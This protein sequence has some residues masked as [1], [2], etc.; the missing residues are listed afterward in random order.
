MS[1]K[2]KRE[3]IEKARRDYEKGSRRYKS[4]ILDHF[5]E[6][7]K[8]TRKHAI[9]ILA[10]GYKATRDRSGR[11]NVYDQGLLL[12]HVK[13]LWFT[14]EQIGSKKMQAALPYWLPHYRGADVTPEIISQLSKMSAS[15]IERYLKIIR[16]QNRPFGRSTTRASHFAK[17]RI[18]I[19]IHDWNRKE[20]GHFEADT[21]A[22]CGD[23]ISGEYAHTI[24]ATD[25]ATTWT[26][27]RSTFT[28]ASG[29]VLEQ[30][31]DIENNLPFKIISF[32]FD[33]GSEFLNYPVLEFL[34]NRETPIKVSRSRPYRKND[35]CFVEQKNYTH[36][37]QLFGYDRIPKRSYV[38]M[39]N[40]IY[41]KY[42][43]PFQ[44][45]FIPTMK[46]IR[47]ERFGAKI[48]K[49]YEKPM[50]PYVRVMKSELIA[51]EQK[52]KLKEKY[53][54]L[55]PFIL[56]EEMEK[57]L[58]TYFSMLRKKEFSQIPDAA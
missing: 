31:R 25:I 28:K 56:K 10:K 40:E 58:K 15:T 5:C 48:K 53:E 32:D 54:S 44:N 4:Y 17:N 14:M 35:Q 55:D 22:H 41:K 52:Q 57:K 43:S 24:T 29:G 26:E 50:T 12:P 18:P 16:F 34:E 7:T 13:R 49:T 3:Y 8:L 21:V 39:M 45:F 27:N 6:V 11:P 9:R 46:L 23:N 2:S 42:W 47:K 33:N 51:E 37:R 36:V 20:P 38:D 30:L 19:R 1:I